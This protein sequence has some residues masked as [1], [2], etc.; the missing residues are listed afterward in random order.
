MRSIAN[1]YLGTKSDVGLHES[2]GILDTVLQASYEKIY[3]PTTR[4]VKR[5]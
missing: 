2:L 1:R 5:V 4:A 3:G